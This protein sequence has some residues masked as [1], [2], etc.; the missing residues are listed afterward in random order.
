MLHQK[1]AENL[2]DLD[3]LFLFLNTHAKNKPNN[4]PS[5]GENENEAVM[6]YFYRCKIS[7]EYFKIDVNLNH[8]S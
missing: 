5:L 6:S 3:Q 4:T 8:H 2:C 7:G 1:N